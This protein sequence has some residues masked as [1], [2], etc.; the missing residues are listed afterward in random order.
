MGRSSACDIRLDDRS[1]NGIAVNG[2]AVDWAPLSDGD[3]IAVGR[4]TLHVIETTG[5]AGGD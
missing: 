1:T 5:H 2:E 4:Y 3:E